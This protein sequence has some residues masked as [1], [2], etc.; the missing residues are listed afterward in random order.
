MRNAKIDVC[1]S[2]LKIVFFPYEEEFIFQ[3][4]LTSRKHIT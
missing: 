3:F 4:E 2:K 1:N